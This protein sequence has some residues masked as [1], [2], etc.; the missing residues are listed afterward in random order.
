LC[1]VKKPVILVPSPN[2]A[3][4]HQRKN[5]EAL[6][7]KNAAIMVKDVEAR[8]VLINNLL[9][10]VKN[11]N[12]QQELSSNISKLAINDAAERIAQEVLKL[13]ND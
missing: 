12:K 11:E 6:A 9:D 5:A 4:D 3:E 2:V 7:I 10:L 1:L 8:N 13:A